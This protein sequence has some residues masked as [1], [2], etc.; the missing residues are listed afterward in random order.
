MS[1]QDLHSA[2]QTDQ[3]PQ[4]GEGHSSRTRRLLRFRTPGLKGFRAPQLVTT[5]GAV[6]VWWLVSLVLEV[7]WLPSPAKVWSAWWDLFR[8]GEFASLT[9]TGRTLAIGLAIVIVLAAIATLVISS[10]ELIEKAV[11]PFINA[12]LATPTIALIP[13]FIT[14][15][16]FKDV[17]RV[18]T[19]ISFALFPVVVTWVEGIKQAPPELLEMGRAFTAG[20]LRQIRSIVLPSAA[21]M[22]VTGFRIGVVQG[23][24]GVVSA[25]VL[26]G[27]IGVG[28]VLQES[29]FDLA[30]LY[31]T[32]LTLILISIGAYVV[33]F[34]VDE[35]LSRRTQGG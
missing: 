5:V 15:W 7:R 21:S 28:R 1:N 6:I 26:V 33:L 22:I 11:E 9:S 23:I 35:R 12:A 18:A 13:V 20:R 14:L 17:T 2:H 30:R 3:Q 32:V 10:S 31:A 25:E 24:K 27:V 34:L 29:A 8:A 16:G 4:I 19:V